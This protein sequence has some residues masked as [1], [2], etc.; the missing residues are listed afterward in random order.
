LKLLDTS[1]VKVGAD[2]AVV[3]PEK[4]FEQAKAA[5]PYLFTLTGAEKGTTSSTSEPPPSG[6]PGLKLAKDMTDA[7]LQAFEEKVGISRPSFYR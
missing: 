4:F 2:G 3:I 1:A 5:K 7:E 6:D